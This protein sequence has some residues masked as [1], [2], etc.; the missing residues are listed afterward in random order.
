ML[1][2]KNLSGGYSDVNI[3]RNVS[4]SVSRG[5]MFGILGPNGSG[6]ST[7]L[8][9][10]SRV[11]SIKHGEIMIDG[12]S[13]QQYSSKKLARL[14]A[15]LP[16]VTSEVFPFTVKETVELGR[17]AHQ[18]GLFQT[19]SP[20]DEAVVQEVMT[21]T[22]IK[23][24]QGVSLQ[25]LS[26][27]ER[28]RA[29]LAQA[30]A[31]EPD[32]LLLDEPTNHLDLSHQKGLLDQLKRWTRQRGLTVVTVFHDLNLA[33]LYCDR[34]LLLNEGE[35][36]CLGT[37]EDVLNETLIQQ[38]Y[39]TVLENHPH[40]EVPKPNMVLI[41]EP[42]WGER[43]TLDENYLSRNDEGV[44]FHSPIPLKTIAS[45]SR[46]SGLGWKEK[47]VISKGRLFIEKNEKTVEMQTHSADQIYTQYAAYDEEGFSILIILTADCHLNY[48]HTWLFI[49]GQVSE[50]TLIESLASALEGKQTALKEKLRPNGWEDGIVVAA[51]QKGENLT[52]GRPSSK[53]GQTILKGMQDCSEKLCNSIKSSLS[54]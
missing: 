16:Q 52:T 14:L 38:V 3:L 42:E 24:F 45:A 8:K 41:P 32:I 19:W 23:E 31:Q 33:S 9:M 18:R 2:V 49:N 25:E 13:L 29:F 54:N 5:E 11:L 27:G 15:V 10:I 20:K 43:T 53:L 39:K 30:L 17:Y 6:K 4:F 34:L 48:F 50:N 37:P 21:L 1:Q 35:V 46:G 44:M 7:L 51:T 40:P 26:G 12:R 36:V 28:Q 47:F 22:K